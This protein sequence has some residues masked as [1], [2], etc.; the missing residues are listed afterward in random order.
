MLEA[1][2]YVESGYAESMLEREKV[3]STYMGMGLAIPH[4]TSET[5]ALVRES[6][7]VVLQYPD[8]VDF[9]EEKARLVIGIAGAGD[10]HLDI[11]AKI[12]SALDDEEVLERLSV[13]SDP[14]DIL[15][16]LE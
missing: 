12:S 15:K 13:T 9:G 2:G 8:G 14:E 5:K 11:L 7:I 16:T 6:G 1:S 3:A 10:A 4:G